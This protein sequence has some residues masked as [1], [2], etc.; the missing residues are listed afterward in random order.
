[1]PTYRLYLLD[2]LGHIRKAELLD[3]ETDAEAIDLAR[4]VD[5]QGHG[6]EIWDG[7]RRVHVF[8]PDN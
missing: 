7:A 3:G 5:R 6:A 8:E 2:G 4:A 1:M